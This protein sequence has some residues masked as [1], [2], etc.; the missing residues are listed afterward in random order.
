MPQSENKAMTQRLP[1]DEYRA[2]CRTILQ[3]DGYR[4]RSCGARNALHVHHIIFRSQGG[5]D[6][7]WNLL[8]LCN[9]CHDGAHKDVKDGEYGLVILVSQVTQEV[10]MRRRPGWRPS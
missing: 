5:P 9:S 10:V 1:E 4:C 8:T 6:E 3:R 2:L 7:A